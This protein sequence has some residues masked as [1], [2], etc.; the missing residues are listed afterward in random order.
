ME[1]RVL[2]DELTTLKRKVDV[3][4]LHTRAMPGGSQEL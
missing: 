3:M 4:D 2:K 1:L